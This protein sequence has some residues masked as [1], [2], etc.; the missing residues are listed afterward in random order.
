MYGY[1]GNTSKILKSVRNVFD[2]AENRM[3]EAR[4]T[5]YILEDLICDGKVHE[6]EHSCD[7]S[8]YLLWHEDWLEDGG[9]L[10][11]SNQERLLGEIIPRD[12]LKP[13][14]SCQLNSISA[15]RKNNSW[16][17]NM[18]QYRVNILWPAKRKALYVKNRVQGLFGL[19]RDISKIIFSNTCNIQPG[20]IVRV[21]KEDEIKSTLDENRKHKG[22]FFMNE[23]YQHCNQD[24]VI[25]KE[26]KFF[27]D[28][29]RKRI[30]KCKDMFMLKG[31]NCS[32][33]QRLYLF[34][35]DRNC[36]FFWHKDWLKKIK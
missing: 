22:C 11:I 23:M 18:L 34:P 17:N 14:K 36:F 3:Y 21:L 29:A 35:C 5:L 32:G 1:C 7:H 30:C 25:L 19:K 20:D 24:Y 6:F 33:R 15:I 12:S 2:E 16:V 8:C 4:P 31:A 26:V 27:Y 28:E 10:K 13:E 9:L